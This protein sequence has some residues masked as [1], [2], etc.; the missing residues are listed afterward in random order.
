MFLCMYFYGLY[1][2]N[3]QHLKVFLKR[4]MNM[5]RWIKKNKASQ[6]IFIGK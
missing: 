6:I 2:V 5:R 3:W 1:Y 4:D